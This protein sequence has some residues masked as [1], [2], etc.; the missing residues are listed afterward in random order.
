MNSITR[1]KTIEDILGKMNFPPYRKKQVFEG[2]YQQYIKSYSEMTSLPKDLRQ[3][4]ADELGIGV[5]SLNNVFE[6]K[7]EQADKVLFETQ[8][9]NRIEAVLMTFKPNPV[10]TDEH[11]SLCIS[12]QS[13]C[14][15]GCTFCATGAVGF[16][17]NLEIDEIT[18]QILY[19]LQREQKVDSVSF[20]G[21]GEPF[22]NP[23]LFDALKI[24][25]DK[26]KMAFSQR[27][28]SIS[29][30]GIVSGI[31]RLQK[32]FP[33]INLAFSLHSPFPEQRLQIMPI[34]KAYPIATV[35]KALKEF[36]RQTNKRVFIAYVL[37]DGVND[38]IDHAKEIAK[39]IKKQGEKQYL[40]HVNLIRFNTGATF[41]PYK[42]PSTGRVN[43][44]RKVLD[45]CGIENTL[46][47]S[48]GVKIDAACGQLYAK[49]EKVKK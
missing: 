38:S 26:D 46:R 36:V 3:I 42:K 7:D 19:F 24:I 22:A 20:M 37:L 23:S 17:K 32:E 28:L 5:L 39:L 30:V 48:F 45:S 27:R 6:T 2:I 31:K 25:T 1:I 40:Y 44:F 33:K 4:L 41:I 34:T 11:Q 18:D 21:M 13:G 10:R 8:D 9:K 14:A 16:K 15:L 35:M 49:Y 43:T 12:S 47:Q 29:T